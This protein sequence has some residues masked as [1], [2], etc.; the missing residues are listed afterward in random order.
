MMKSSC[1]DIICI[2]GVIMKIKKKFFI[3]CAFIAIC[4]VIAS[5]IMAKVNINTATIDT[6]SQLEGIGHSK[7]KA[8]IDYRAA[9]GGFKTIDELAQVKGVSKKIIDMNRGQIDVVSNGA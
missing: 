7:A 6:L 3:K 4:G 5:P 8:I 2:H 1:S 9:H